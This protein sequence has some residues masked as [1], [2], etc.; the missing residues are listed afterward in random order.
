MSHPAGRYIWR[1]YPDPGGDARARSVERASQARRHEEERPQ[2]SCVWRGERCPDL[3][4]QED[5]LCDWCGN[6][7]TCADHDGPHV[8]VGPGQLL[9]ACWVDRQEL[10]RAPC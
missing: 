10:V 3:A 9:Q 2:C 4:T 5:G 8:D 1:G 7:D 6:H